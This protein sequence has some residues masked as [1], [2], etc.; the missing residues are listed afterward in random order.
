V[1]ERSISYAP[2]PSVAPE[3]EGAALANVYRFILDCHT[4]KEATT[5]PVSCPDTIVRSAEEVSN[6]E[7]RPD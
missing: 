4:K 5:S 6:V 1:G 7:R 2:R 3:L